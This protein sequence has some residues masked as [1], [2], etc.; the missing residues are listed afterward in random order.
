MAFGAFALLFNAL[1]L[2]SQT[3]DYIM[4]QWSILFIYFV[5]ACNVVGLNRLRSANLLI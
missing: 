3:A 5:L 1:Q 4:A 2:D